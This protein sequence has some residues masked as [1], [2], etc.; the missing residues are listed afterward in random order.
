M[1]FFGDLTS[2]LTLCFS[3]SHSDLCNLPLRTWFTFLGK[4]GPPTLK[5][6]RHKVTDPLQEMKCV[7]ALACNSSCLAACRR[8]GALNSTKLPLGSLTTV[9]LPSGMQ[10]MQPCNKLQLGKRGICGISCHPIMITD[11]RVQHLPAG[12]PSLPAGV[13]RSSVIFHIHLLWLMAGGDD[14]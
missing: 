1:H 8:E 7:T 2:T 3:I 14:A 10:N 5:R 11:S 12:P 9:A 13:Q 6:K 4:I